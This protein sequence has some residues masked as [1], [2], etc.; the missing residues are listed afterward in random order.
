LGKERKRREMAKR[1]EREKERGRHASSIFDWGKKGGE[2]KGGISA[3]KSFHSKKEEE[4][5][6][7]KSEIEKKKG[8]GKEG[9]SIF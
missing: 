4:K 8:K 7:G 9:S 6:K 2:K 1:R 5:R 3:G